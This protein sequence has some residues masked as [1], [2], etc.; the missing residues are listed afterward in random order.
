MPFV[1]HRPSIPRDIDSGPVFRTGAG[2][3]FRTYRCHFCLHGSGARSRFP[4]QAGPVFRTGIL[5]LSR[6]Q[7]EP[8][9]AYIHIR[10]RGFCIYVGAVRVVMLPP[11]VGRG[12]LDVGESEAVRLSLIANASRAPLHVD[13]AQRPNRTKARRDR[14][15]VYAALLELAARDDQLTVLDAAMAHMLD[16][17]NCEHRPLNWFERPIGD[18]IEH[19]EPSHD[20]RRIGLVWLMSLGPLAKLSHGQRA[21]WLWL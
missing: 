21:P 7:T 19:L 18:A 10:T 13:E 11:L 1:R 6:P 12:R 16:L 4:D 9:G 3:V 8:S 15:L 2:P 17:K 5:F 20:E 14:V